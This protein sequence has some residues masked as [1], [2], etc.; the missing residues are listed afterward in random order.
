M[1]IL[2]EARLSLNLLEF[3]D[4]VPDLAAFLRER[5]QFYLRDILGYAYDEVNAAM[6]A[7]F[8][9]LADLANR[10]EAIHYVRP[11]EDFEPLAASFKRIKNILKQAQVTQADQPNQNLLSPGPE[12][13]LYQAFV[14]VRKA[15]EEHS[16]YREK[17]GGNRFASTESGSLLR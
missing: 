1:K 4:T 15:T 9:T 8:T 11:T 2:F 7:P 13:E 3:V 14:D 12:Q 5:I 10:V 6:A 16:D 17:L